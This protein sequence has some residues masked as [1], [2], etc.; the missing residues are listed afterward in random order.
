M[1]VTMHALKLAVLA[2]ELDALPVLP[3]PAFVSD[4]FEPQADSSSAAAVAV[5]RATVVVLLVLSSWLKFLSSFQDLW[6]PIFE[7]SAEEI[8]RST[9]ASRHGCRE[10]TR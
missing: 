9:Y 3:A 8:P 7:I 4:F 6:S 5:A 2:P 1:S 10:K